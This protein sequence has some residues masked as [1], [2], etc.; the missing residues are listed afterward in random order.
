MSHEAVPNATLLERCKR[1]A[2][3]HPLVALVIV[4]STTVV[5]TSQL[6]DSADALAVRLGI[7]PGALA[8][9]GS[10]ARGSYSRSLTHSAYIRLFWANSF[11]GRLA[12]KGR[13]ADVDLA[14]NEY[15]ATVANWSA[16]LVN[17]RTR[18]TE[19][20]GEKKRIAFDECVDVPLKTLHASLLA[21]RYPVSNAASVDSVILADAGRVADSANDLILAFATGLQSDGGKERDQ[22][23][24]AD[25]LLI[26][27]CSSTE[28]W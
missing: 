4:V 5:G 8:L 23:S 13:P 25:S 11:V 9:A 12:R 17:N 2:F 3:D 7:R 20:Y 22:R 28:N 10:D 16:E 27:R 1:A 19:F 24:P 18:L 15:M 26:S 14:W 6:V 21:I